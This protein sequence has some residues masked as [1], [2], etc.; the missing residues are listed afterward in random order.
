MSGDMSPPPGT[1]LLLCLMSPQTQGNDLAGTA[2]TARCI[3]LCDIGST[4]RPSSSHRSLA[5]RNANVNAVM[6]PKGSPFFFF[7]NPPAD[8][9]NKALVFTTL[10]RIF[11]RVVCRFTSVAFAA[12][13]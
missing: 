4:L 12:Q 2:T 8:G 11:I 9:K 13:R 10:P 3:C 7:F 6:T 5:N 1:L